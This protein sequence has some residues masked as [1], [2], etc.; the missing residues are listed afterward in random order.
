MI[1]STTHYEDNLRAILNWVEVYTGVGAGNVIWLDQDTPRPPKP[2]AGIL[3]I[4]SG[5]RFGFDYVDRTFD[6]PNQR[7]QR[8]TSGPRQLVAQIEVYTDPVKTLAEKDAPR[9]LEDALMAL[10][11]IEVRD[12]FRVA[13]IGVLN[14][15][16]VNRL[17]EQFGDRWERR[18]QADVT[19]LYSG[20]MFDDGVGPSGDWVETVEVLTESNGNLIISE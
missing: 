7:V 5:M 18:A 16:L 8:K 3:I 10:D 11:S 2:Y 17:D 4:N 20:E 15:T 12:A 19:F 13:K 1:T 14:H 6:D 9:M